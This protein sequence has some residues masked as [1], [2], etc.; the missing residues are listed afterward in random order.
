MSDDP[1]VLSSKTFTWQRQGGQPHPVL[2]EEIAQGLLLGT[3][4]NSRPSGWG[5]LTASSMK[6]K[7]MANF[8][9]TYITNKK[10]FKNGMFTQGGSRRRKTRRR[11]T[12]RRR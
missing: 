4:D 11:H 9:D 6:G 12:R 10:S 1:D 8:V 7:S 5:G 3:K 2:V